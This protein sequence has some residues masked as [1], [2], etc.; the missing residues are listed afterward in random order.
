MV[1]HRVERI[2]SRAFITRSR[3]KGTYAYGLVIIGFPHGIGRTLQFL[4]QRRQLNY[5]PVAVYPIHL[6]PDTG[7]IERNTDHETL[8][9]RCKR[10]RLPAARTRVQR[11]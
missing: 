2:A 10:T 1:A 11:S 3:R 8:R 6:N 7:L 9:E 4:G 5:R